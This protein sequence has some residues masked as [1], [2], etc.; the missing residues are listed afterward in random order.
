M[1][2]PGDDDP[3][4]EPSPAVALGLVQAALVLA[5]FPAGWLL[6]QPPLATLAWDWAGLGWGVVAALPMV[7]LFFL[8]Y[9]VPVGPF[10]PVRRF[11][12]EVVVPLLRRCS[13][14]E[15]FALSLLAGVGEELLFRGVVQA[16]LTQRT[17]FVAGLALASLL[18]GL[19][20][21]FTLGY[22]LLTALLGAYLG[23]AWVWTGNLLVPV[24]AHFLYDFVA[25]V[26]LTRS[27]ATSSP[28]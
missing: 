21:P 20:H 28:A 22:V 16:A 1:T 26:Y 3:I 19:M 2:G 18:F 5:A 25:M 13:L 4:P 24:V 6:G 11:T 9:H 15:L 14:F 12:E 10:G 17:D 23:L 7:G 27:P 8:L